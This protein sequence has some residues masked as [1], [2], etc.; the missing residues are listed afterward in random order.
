MEIQFKS[1][2]VELLVKKG[3]FFKEW[4]TLVLADMHFGKS[5]HFRKSGIPVPNGVHDTN[6]EN[7]IKVLQYKKPQKV[8]F[9]GDLFHSFHNREWKYFGDVLAQFPAVKFV[10]VVGNHD[11]LEKSHYRDLGIEIVED[12]LEMGGFLLTH[13]PIEAYAGP[14]YNLC[15]HLHPGIRL[16]GKA[17][18]SL[19]LSCYFFKE[20]QGI[21]PAFGAFTG[22]AVQKPREKDGVYVVA[23]TEV[24]CVNE[25]KYS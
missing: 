15:G 2:L 8:I 11:I 23:N 7:L 21:V 18:Q 4:Q 13:E 10:L 24:V 5:G 12:G 3:L 9:L 1:T 14:L 19:R 25:F 6:M 22:L 16:H 20:H 17:R